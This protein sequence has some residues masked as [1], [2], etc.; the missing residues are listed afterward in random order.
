MS[1]YGK[2]MFPNDYLAA[3]PEAK[4]MTREQIEA[5]RFDTSSGNVRA[6]CTLALEGLDMRERNENLEGIVGHWR[7]EHAA[8]RA[9]NE[10][11]LTALEKA[12][13][14]LRWSKIHLREQG[15]GSVSVEVGLDATEAALEKKPE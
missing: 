11:L 2:S 6:L 3:Q 14:G 8:L 13:A 10:R 1:S 15:T 5:I 9:Q 7:D 4:Q 12:R